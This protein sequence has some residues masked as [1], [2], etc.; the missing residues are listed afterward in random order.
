M[1]L[2]NRKRLIDLE[3]ELMVAGGRM[4]E[5]IVGE[6]GMNRY[7]LL[8]LKWKTNK[9]LLYSAGNSAQCYVADWMGE[10]FGGRKDTSVK[11]KRLI[12]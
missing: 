1:N 2:E 4:G 10:E 7:T 5:G 11:K 12:L 8:C 3:K 6:F 9:G